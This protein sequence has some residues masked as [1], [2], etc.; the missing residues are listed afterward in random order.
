MASQ[1]NQGQN[2]DQLGRALASS[3]S[4]KTAIKAVGKA[5]VGD[6]TGAVLDVVKDGE[7][8]KKIVAIILV[9]CF[10]VAF[11]FIAL[12]SA[13]IMVVEMVI[14]LWNKNYDELV[15]QN[16]IESRGNKLWLMFDNQDTVFQATWDTLVDLFTGTDNHESGTDFDGDDYQTTVDSVI[17][18][19]AL[20][21]ADGAL[22]KRIE[23][24]RGRV[25]ERGEQLLNTLTEYKWDT[26]GLQI[27]LD[28]CEKAN[29]YFLYNGI[30]GITLNVDTNCF[31]LS[32]IQCVKILAA[33]CVQNECDIHSADIVD[34]MDYLGW[35]ALDNGSASM[36]DSVDAGTIYETPLIGRFVDEFYGAYSSGTAAGTG[37]TNSI[38]LSPPS[39][40]IW[41]GN[42]LP[43]YLVEEM[44][45]L[46]AMEADGKIVLPRN[47][48]GDIDWEECSAHYK[49]V[50]GMGIIDYLYTG[51]AFAS[52]SRTEYTG[53]DESIDEFLAELVDKGL[54][55]IADWWNSL[56]GNEKPTS[57]SATKQGVN[58]KCTVK[59]TMYAD[60][61]ASTYS[62]ITSEDL[63]VYHPQSVFIRQTG[64]DV[65]NEM[66]C[67]NVIGGDE[68]D[69]PIIGGSH[70][71]E[72]GLLPDTEYSIYISSPNEN[73]ELVYEWVD[74]FTTVFDTDDGT[75]YQAYQIAISIDVTYRARSVDELA[76]D[77]VGLW[78]GNLKDVES[79]DAGSLRP[80]GHTD[81]SLL[82]LTWNDF[83][84]DDSGTSQS[85]T[86]TRMR[87]YQYEYYLDYVAGVADTLNL[88]TAG[89]F[90][91]EFNYGDT[92]VSIANEEFVYYTMNRLRD[93]YRYW[94]I[95]ASVTGE[96][97]KTESRNGTDWSSVFVL[98]CAYQCGY[99][100]DDACFGGFGC[101]AATWPISCTDLYN[102]MITYSDAECCADAEYT[103]SP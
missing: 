59:K 67:R 38:E 16:A 77:I 15:T 92:L 2:T 73:G 11:V 18:Q 21:G 13:I 76:L 64:S 86:F 6:V 35:Y 48:H 102:S 8:L 49:S 80:I 3:K 82:K 41:K 96:E 50:A 33:Y 22:M 36:E 90:A 32:D 66:I 68:I 27:A 44:A 93:G 20:A 42:F 79:N 34:L 83:I 54:D 39:I 101:N 84:T 10:L 89:V 69:Q 51:S 17:D 87:G 88:D 72:G 7:L 26:L 40:P 5:A 100:G 56:W 57:I 30:S 55:A 23:L 43:Q 1:E 28:I 99:L 37:D 78:P 71:A 46:K 4:A 60:G 94:D 19:E 63:V 65:Y 53:I 12:G 98:C 52:F 9:I 14:T 95:C 74:T 58:G 47:L 103:P 81:N 91:P 25:E 75:V 85:V 62:V 24:I 31:S 45:Q 70:F 97:Y 61:S 29:N